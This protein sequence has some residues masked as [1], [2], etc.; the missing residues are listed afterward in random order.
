MPNQE[1]IARR[2]EFLIK[3]YRTEHLA[4]CKKC[5]ALARKDQ[6]NFC[7]ICGK[8]LSEIPMDATLSI[9]S[10]SIKIPEN[11]AGLFEKDLRELI[12]SYTVDAGGTA[13][14]M[15]VDKLTPTGFLRKE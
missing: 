13:F 11:V 7:A 9:S 10:F 12:D 3:Q 1:E 4:L 14:D 15:I 8:K 6:A 5:M 2:N